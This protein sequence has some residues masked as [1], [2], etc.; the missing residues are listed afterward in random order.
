MALSAVTLCIINHNGAEHLRKAFHAVQ[1]QSWVFSEV[2][3]VDNASSD[4]S[5]EVAR[6]M[7]PEAR[8]IQLPRNLGPGAARN[9]GFTAAAHD[10][11]LFQDN[12]IRLDIDTAEQLVSHLQTWP[13][14]LAVAP[15]VLYANAPQRFNSTA[16]IVI[17]SG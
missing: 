3:L 12:D 13:D 7:C 11:I 1:A 6:A 16:R 2:L 17:S 15:R 8:V 5:L 10:L 4:D 14:A 9:A